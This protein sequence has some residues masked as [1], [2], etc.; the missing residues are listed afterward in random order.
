MCIIAKALIK[1]VL[2]LKP[3]AFVN[4]LHSWRTAICHHAS[5]CSDTTNSNDSTGTRK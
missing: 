3:N 1:S 2:K 5:A 4:C